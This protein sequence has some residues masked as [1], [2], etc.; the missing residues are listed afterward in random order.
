MVKLMYIITPKAGIHQTEFQRYWLDV[1][2]P[3]VKKISLLKRYVINIARPRRD[4]TS[5][6]I[7]GVAELWFESSDAMTTALATVEAKNARA[8][9]QKFSDVGRNVSGLVDEHIVREPRS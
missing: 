9:I 6:P 3:I 5:A 7:G 8:D 2:A 1:H 4:G